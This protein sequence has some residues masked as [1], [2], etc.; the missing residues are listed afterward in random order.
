MLSTNLPK[1]QEK[2]FS[3][4]IEITIWASISFSRQVYDTVSIGQ[5]L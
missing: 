2:S 1:L 4:V 3:F 5:Y